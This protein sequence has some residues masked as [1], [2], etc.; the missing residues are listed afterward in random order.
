M[1]NSNSELYYAKTQLKYAKKCIQ[2]IVNLESSRDFSVT[3]LWSEAKKQANI[4]RELMIKIDPFAFRPECELHD[5]I[6][7]NGMDGKKGHH[8]KVCGEDLILVRR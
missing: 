4:A 5:P 3:D 8:C 2:A 7:H 6:A 1:S